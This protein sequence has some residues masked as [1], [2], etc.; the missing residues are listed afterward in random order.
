MKEWISK[1]IA[2]LGKP[3]EKDSPQYKKEREQ[4]RSDDPKVRKKLATKAKTRPEILYYLAGDDDEAVRRAVAKNKST[5]MKADVLLAQDKSVDVRMV[6]AKRL[7][8]LLPNVSLDEHSQLYSFTV[9]ALATLARDEVLKI[10]LALSSTLKDKVYTPNVIASRL[11]KDAE[12]EVAEPILRF[13]VALS[14]EDLLE[15]IADH[16]SSWVLTAIADRDQVNESVTDAIIETENEGAGSVLIQNEG[17]K[18]FPQT[19]EMVVEKASEITAWQESLV[20]R[21]SLP[22]QL[23]RELANFVDLSLFRYL[24]KRS[25]FDKQTREEIVSVVRRRIEFENAI[26]GQVDKNNLHNQVFSLYKEGR[27]KD[28]LIGDALS[29]RQFDFVYASL[30]VLTKSPEEIIRKIIE[31]KKAK[32]I[33]ALCWGAGLS[34]RTAVKIQT[35]LALVPRQEVVLARGGTDYPLEEKELIWQ[36]DFLGLSE[37]KH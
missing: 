35:D 8:D 25:D 9:G 14:D 2:G 20:K 5:P 12:Q 7:M 4:A 29:W 19:L 18:F 26:G 37:G 3:T 11:A 33:V 10:R 34:M 1:A 22:V 30:A 13:C 32:P 15:I 23:A 17:A 27:L 28:E 31:S 16:P 36:L 24:E 21:K 6:L